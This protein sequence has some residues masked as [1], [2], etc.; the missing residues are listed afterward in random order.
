MRS[1]TRTLAALAAVLV[2]VVAP[3]QGSARPQGSA[4]PE[5]QLQGALVAQINAFRAAHGLARLRVSGALN[6]V[7]EGHSAQMARLGYFSHNSANGQSFSARI[8]GAYSPRGYRSWSV[9]ENLVWGGPDIGA[10]RA[11]RLWLSSPPH[12]ANLLNARWREVGLG[13]VHSSSAPGV[14]GGGP[15]TIVTADFGARTR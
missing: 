14:Y 7:A 5:S 9:G 11:F 1:N 2:A 13:A 4:V 3:A 12:R 15:A 10:V 6:G 8:A